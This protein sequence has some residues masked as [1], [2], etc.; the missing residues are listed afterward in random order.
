RGTVNAWD[1]D[2]SFLHIDTQ[3][4]ER[5]NGGYPAL[6]KILPLLDSGNVNPFGPNDPTKTPG[7]PAAADA[8]Q[9]HGNAY[10]TK[11]SIDSAQAKLTHDLMQMA[12]GPLALA[13]G[14]EG[15]KEGF[16]VDASPEIQAGDISGYGGNFLP[17][18]KSRNVGAGFAEINMPFIRTLEVTAAARY[19]HY[20]GVGD[21]TSPKVSARWTPTKQV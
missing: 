18:N 7:T 3:L 14:A 8:T 19:D 6:P 2:A 17:V 15:R 10:Q 16:R 21:R 1:Y 4:K 20:E 12:G 13:L 9:F 11:T 5:V